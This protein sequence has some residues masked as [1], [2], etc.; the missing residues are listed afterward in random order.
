MWIVFTL[1]V[2][3]FV[4]YTYWNEGVFAGFCMLVATVLSGLITFQFWEPLATAFESGTKQ[5]FLDGYQDCV[6]MI[7]LFC[8][9]LLAMRAGIHGM[10]KSFFLYHPYVQQFGGL[11]FGLLNGYLISGFLLCVFQTL[12][13]HQNFWGFTPRTL[14]EPGYRS[15]MPADRVWLAMMRYGGAYPFSGTRL[16]LDTNDPCFEDQTAYTTYNTFDRCGTFEIR[17]FRYRRYDDHR[18][19]LPHRGEAEKYVSFTKKKIKKKK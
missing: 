8:L 10:T 6:C 4:A 11:A 2:M 13:W 18:E 16:F 9:S 12:P 3:A 15:V 19:V 7:G 1:A 17:Y 14:N 5:T